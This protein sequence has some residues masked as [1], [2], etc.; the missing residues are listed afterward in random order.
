MTVL[1]LKITLWYSH[2]QALTLK[3]LTK[4]HRKF[5][6]PLNST[7]ISSN[8]FINFLWLSIDILSFVSKEN[9][10]FLYLSLFYM[11][12]LYIYNEVYAHALFIF[13]ILSHQNSHK[14]SFQNY[15]PSIFFF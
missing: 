10:W 1:T 4:Q 14:A 12:F 7:I 6:Y 15:L 9:L 3:I 13:F 5:A 8:I 11:I 2:S